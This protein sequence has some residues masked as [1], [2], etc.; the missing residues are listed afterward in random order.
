MCMLHFTR[1]YIDILQEMLL[2]LM[3]FCGKF[4]KVYVCQKLLKYSLVWQTYGKNKTVQFFL[5]H[6]VY[7]CYHRLISWRATFRYRQMCWLF[8]VPALAYQRGT[9]GHWNVGTE[10]ASHDGIIVTSL[11][12]LRYHFWP[13]YLFLVSVVCLYVSITVIVS[14]V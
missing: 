2:S 5:P 12:L 4:I 11:Q 1:H 8:V 14:I 7:C 10:P 13:I 9:P 3:L 6:S